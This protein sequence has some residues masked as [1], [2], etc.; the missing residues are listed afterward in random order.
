MVPVA[1]FYLWVGNLS[2]RFFEKLESM[3][4]G[5]TVRAAAIVAATLCFGAAL[6]WPERACNGYEMG[7]LWNARGDSGDVGASYICYCGIV[8]VAVQGT[9]CG[10]GV[11]LDR[12][13]FDVDNV[14]PYGSPPDNAHPAVGVYNLSRDTHTAV[15][16]HCGEALSVDFTAVSR[17]KEAPRQSRSVGEIA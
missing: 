9:T 3:F 14:S 2:A 7:Q 13:G 6:M 15:A 5:A 1:V 11:G 12:G 8:D 16:L 17:A 4:S 10:C